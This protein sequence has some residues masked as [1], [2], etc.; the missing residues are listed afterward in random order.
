VGEET[1]PLV[2]PPPGEIESLYELARTGNLYAIQ[3]R[4]GH[5]ET[6]GESY[7]PFAHKLQELAGSFQVRALV[8]FL[9]QYVEQ[10]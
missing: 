4:A 1:A 2:L 10:G 9:K 6:L 8:D 3:E 7:V 5:I